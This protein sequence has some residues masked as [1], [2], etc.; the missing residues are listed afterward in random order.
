[1]PDLCTPPPQLTGYGAILRFFDYILRD[2]VIIGGT[3]DITMPGVMREKIE[4]NNDNGDGTKHYLV[5]PQS[6][7]EDI[8]TEIDL[9]PAQHRKL[10]KIVK[11]N[12]PMYTTWQVVLNTP[13]QWTLQW[14][15]SPL[16]LLGN[17]PKQEVVTSTL[18]IGYTGGDVAFEKLA[19]L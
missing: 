9:I 14:C 16:G 3:S 7:T 17:I 4:I 19:D 18:T 5:L 8:E 10:L 15:G 13:D 11:Q 2:W 6:D 12:P 1:M